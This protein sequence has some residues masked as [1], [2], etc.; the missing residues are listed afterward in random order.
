ME[1]MKEGIDANSVALNSNGSALK[2]NAIYMDSASAKIN[3]FKESLKEIW[4]NTIDSS[5][6]KGVVSGGTAI[7]NIFNQLITT[8]GTFPT[9]IGTVVA[10]LTLFNA[11]FREMQTAYQ[12][13]FLSSIVAQLNTYGNSLKSLT[14]SI[15]LKIAEQ[16]KEIVANQMSGDSIEGMKANLISLNGQLVVTT[17]KLALVRIGAAAL[18]AAFSMGL[19]L[20]ISGIMT[21]ID[22]FIHIM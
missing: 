8:F 7:L 6:I 22:N 18:S 15:K 12:P 11:K 17:A 5:A 10:G 3:E 16:R 1:N 20:A 13:T 4:I 21:A 19:S 9:V 14:E 2:E